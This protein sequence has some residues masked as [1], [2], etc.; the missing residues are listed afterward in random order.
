MELFLLLLMIAAGGIIAVAFLVGVAV[1]QRRE[2][3][4]VARESIDRESLAASIVTQI[5]VEGG[6]TGQEAREALRRVGRNAGEVTG[7]IDLQTWGEAFSRISSTAD[8][9][10]LLED[11]VVAAVIRSRTLPQSQYSALMN[12]AFAL[13]FHTDSLAMLRTRYGFDSVPRSRGSAESRP[14]FE[15][16]TAGAVP[17]DRSLMLSVLGL[18]G[19]ADRKSVVSTYRRL[20]ALHHP[21]RF[22]DH[23]ADERAAAAE[24]FIQITRVYERLMASEGWD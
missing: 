10:A 14:L 19:D 1:F 2:R 9:E 20:A 5:V 23:P 13:G 24:R 17:D 12:L 22:H 15:K 6:A 11:C 16:A 7:S 18:G 4:G 3:A 8:R 21:D